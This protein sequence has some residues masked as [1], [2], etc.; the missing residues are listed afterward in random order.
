MLSEKYPLEI[1]VAEDNTINQILILR[2]F[3]M[4]GYSIQIAENGYEAIEIL[5]RMKIDI[6]FMDIKMPKMDGLEAT[7]HIVEQWGD[8]RP[9]IIA[10]TANALPIEK[11]TYFAAGMVDYISKPLTVNQISLCIEKWAQI[12]TGKIA[13]KEE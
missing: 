13:P 12:C 5:N 11:E 10:I 7:R 9:P 1:L 2:M 4:L 8:Q 6:V 3:Q